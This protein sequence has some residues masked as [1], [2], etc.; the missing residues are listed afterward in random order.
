M[1]LVEDPYFNE[2]G[3]ERSA[4]TPAGKR[5]AADYNAQVRPQA[6]SIIEFPI[7]SL[8]ALTCL[9]LYPEFH[10]T[11]RSP[12]AWSVS[13]MGAGRGGGEYCVYCCRAA[14]L[15][16]H[17]PKAHTDLHPCCLCHAACPAGAAGHSHTCAAGS[18]AAA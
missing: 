8:N 4:S 3:Y 18:A 6:A 10:N 13:L 2:P 15:N 9:L 7:R 5:A 12:V 1:V 11:L 17:L 16:K 14:V